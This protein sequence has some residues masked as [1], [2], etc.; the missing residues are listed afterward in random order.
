MD[1]RRLKN[2]EATRE[3]V[4]HWRLRYGTKRPFIFRHSPAALRETL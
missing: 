1:Q 2:P 3:S 4:L